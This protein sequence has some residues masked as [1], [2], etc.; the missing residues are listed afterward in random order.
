MLG[1]DQLN[2]FLYITYV[3]K[4]EKYREMRQNSKTDSKSTLKIKNKKQKLSPIL[5]LQV[6]PLSNLQR[7]PLL[8]VTSQSF[9][10]IIETYLCPNL[11]PW[12]VYI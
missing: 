11:Y 5:S 10:G 1:S 8:K 6:H 3:F 9:P 12:L 4:Y 2:I 7:Q